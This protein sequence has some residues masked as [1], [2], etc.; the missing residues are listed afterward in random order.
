MKFFLCLLLLLRQC[1][2]AGNSQD[3]PISERSDEAHGTAAPTLPHAVRGSASPPAAP[4]LPAPGNSAEA[5][6]AA[7]AIQNAC[8]ASSSTTPRTQRAPVSKNQG[9]IRAKGPPFCKA[10]AAGA[11]AAP[12]ATAAANPSW[13]EWPQHSSLPWTPWNQPGFDTTQVVP[14]LPPCPPGVDP[15]YALIA[16]L[17]T[18]MRLLLVRI[19]EVGLGV[20]AVAQVQARFEAEQNMMRVDENRAAAAEH[21]E[22]KQLLRAHIPQPCSCSSASAAASGSADPPGGPPMAKPRPQLPRPLRPRPQLPRPPVS[23][24]TSPPAPLLKRPRGSVAQ[25]IQFVGTRPRRHAWPTADGQ[26]SS[27]SSAEG[28][29]DPRFA[30][31]Y[32]GYAAAAACAAASSVAAAS[33]SQRMTHRTSAELQMDLAVAAAAVAAVPRPVLPQAQAGPV[34]LGP[35]AAVAVPRAAVPVPPPAPVHPEPCPEPGSGLD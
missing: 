10:K 11:A 30:A 8:A 9:P 19:N 4:A 17:E 28:Y 22:I 1:S 24:P 23:K 6:G 12:T 31:A 32:P 7:R 25:E 20:A 3:D 21:A 5:L 2:A 27:G 35:P 16:G 33:A 34:A 29:Q 14:L 15:R 18:Y 26:L 13:A